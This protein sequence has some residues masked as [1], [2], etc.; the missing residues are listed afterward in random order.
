MFKSIGHR[1][2]ATAARARGAELRPLSVPSVTRRVGAAAAGVFLLA[3][4]LPAQAQAA[5]QPDAK[6]ADQAKQRR[7]DYDSRESLRASAARPAASLSRAAVAAPSGAAVRKLLDQ[8][9]VQGVVD[10][11]QVTGTPR[12]VAR[13]DGFLTA[14]SRKQPAQIALDYV[15][16]HA[17]L[18]GL[19]DAQIAQLT[20]RQDY[21]D[22][23]KTH[24]LSFVQTI[25]GVPVF[26]NGLKAHVAKDGRLIQLDGSPLKA[27]AAPAGAAKL[28]A[29]AARAAAVKDVFGTSNAQVAKTAAGVTT[30]TDGGKASQVYFLTG[31][32]PRLA[33]QTVT[34][35]EGYVHVID[36]ATGD[37]LYRRSTQAADT[38]EAWANY[39]GAAKGGKQTAVNLTKWLPNDSPRLAGNVAHVYSDVND[40][41]KANPTEEVAPSGKRKFVYPFTKFD[42]GGKCSAATQ[43]SWDPATPNSWQ[44]NRAQN[45]VQMYYFLGTWH[46]HLNAAPIG[47]TRSAGNFEAVDGDAVQGQSDDGANTAAGLPDG[48]HVDNANMNTPPDGT[49]P[50]MQ[51][52]LFEPDALFLAG[53]SGD[54]SGVV[55][56]EYTHGLSNRLVVDAGGLSTLGDVQAGSMGEAWSDWYAEDYLVDQGLEKDTATL[57]DVRVGKYVTGGD[58]IR[59]EPLDCPVGA[60][61]AP[62]DGTPGAGPGGYTYGDFGHVSARGAEVHAD[63]EI[64]AQTLWDL[65]TA[66][67]S[68]KAESLVTRAMELSPSNPSFLDERNSILQADLVVNR[69]K[70]QKTIWKVFAKRGMGYF[71]AAVDGDDAQPVEDFSLPPAAN[72]P[73]GTLTG[74]V[75]D[76]DTKAPVA[77][78]SVGFGGHASGFAGDYLATTGADGTYTISGIIPGTY[79]KVFAK[80]AGYDIVVKTVSVPSRTVRLDWQVRRDW[81]AASGGASIVSFTGPDYTPACGPGKLIDQS[82][83]GGWGSD[84]AAAGQNAVIKLP[85]PVTVSDLVINPSATCGDDPSASTG[86]Y[87]VETSVNGTTWTVGAQ[88]TFPVGTVTATSVPLAAGTGTGIGYIRFTMLTTQG[89]DAGDCPAGQPP[90]ESGCVFMDSTELSVYG[91]GS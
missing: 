2:V 87:R 91:A 77:G 50:T 57:G 40:D 4:L 63:G 59:S 26:G 38:G 70:L 32:G 62:C 71:A 15:R 17:D 54:E 42:V 13:L 22:I 68:K 18:F 67:G 10:I 23:A 44:V 86:G 60:T 85:A 43:C 66:I 35:D 45:A 34:T 19:D 64:W 89:Q 52:Y 31:A 20:L 83:S 65:R 76:Q 74:K 56:H 9:G 29:S 72:T 5:P 12:R 81:A 25:G 78:L 58:T 36:A 80:G 46:D 14:A 61:A 37:V 11:D 27:L 73:R 75:T 55:Y 21:V 6:T 84:V 90:T 7:A 69:G 39:P 16:A 30:F 3:G 53:N 79:A 8:L 28:T 41:N 24:H 47:F 49:P 51:M 1:R 33:W 82:Q 88:G 48:D